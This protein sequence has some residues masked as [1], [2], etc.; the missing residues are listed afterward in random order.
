M[1]LTIL[2]AKTLGKISNLRIKL[3]LREISSNKLTL[4][5]RSEIIRNNI[6]ASFR[7]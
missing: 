5:G 6:N 2:N 1:N 4:I 7:K 3:S